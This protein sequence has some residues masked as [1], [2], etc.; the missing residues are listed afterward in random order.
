MFKKISAIA[1]SLFFITFACKKA[2]VCTDQLAYQIDSFELRINSEN[3]G[4]YDDEGANTDSTIG[5][6]RNQLMFIPNKVFKSAQRQITKTSFGLDI[7]PSAYA[8]DCVQIENS[9]TQFD[10]LK[11]DFHIN[12]DLDLSI[13]GPEYSGVIPAG[14]NLLSNQKLRAT[15]L[16][17]LVSRAYLNGGLETPLTLSPDFLRPLNGQHL[18]FTLE[19]T[20]T[21]GIIMSS[22]VDVVVDVNV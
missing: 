22:S 1:L 5:S 11:T 4:L 9:L 18:Q 8:R 3:L 17:D 6:T 12:K 10:P 16:N 14:T 19:L 20:S 15:L 2:E 21:V 13:F 7:I